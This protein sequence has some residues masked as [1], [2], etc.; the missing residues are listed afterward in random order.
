MNENS[1]GLLDIN[2]HLSMFAKKFIIKNRVDRWLDLL[3]RRPKKIFE[4]SSDIFDHLDS[5]YCKRNDELEN[6]VDQN[7]LG[8]FYN[9]HGEPIVITFK[10][11][12]DLG[13]YKNAIF[14]IKSGKLAVF[15]FHE[16]WN[17]ICNR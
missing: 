7:T 10:E 15:F 13:H 5:S 6:V 14:S 4:K 3:V 9:F 16:G 12:V 11:A 1:N 8:V 17:Y 2:D